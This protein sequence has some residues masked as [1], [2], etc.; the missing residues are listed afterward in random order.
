[1]HDPQAPSPAP[2]PGE[3]N[4]PA[5]DSPVQA[6]RQE[7]ESFKKR[8]R[9]RALKMKQGLLQIVADIDDEY[10]LRNRYGHCPHCGKPL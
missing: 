4:A 9:Q 5:D 8:S 7:F 10:N 1:M 6:L 3:A 2:E